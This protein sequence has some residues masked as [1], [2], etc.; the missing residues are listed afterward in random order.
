MDLTSVLLTSEGL[1]LASQLCLGK[2]QEFNSVPEYIVCHSISSIILSTGILTQAK[3]KEVTLQV[4]VLQQFYTP[5]GIETLFANLPPPNS[6]VIVVTDLINTGKSTYTVA[7]HFLEK[8]L[9][10]AGVLT[11]VSTSEQGR[12]YLNNSLR[13]RIKFI[14]NEHS[15]S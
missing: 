10:V 7:E 5:E 2:L 8:G 15:L 4:S 11:L 9:T 12:N 1:E 3:L 14:L 13:V 6:R